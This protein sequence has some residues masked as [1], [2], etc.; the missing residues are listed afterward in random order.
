MTN[1][2]IPVTQVFRWAPDTCEDVILEID[3]GAVT[4]TKKYAGDGAFRAFLQDF[5]AGYRVFRP[6]DFPG[7]EEA[8]KAMGI[9]SI[10]V[11]YGF[12][13]HEPVIKMPGPVSIPGKI[14]LCWNP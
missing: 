3:V 14:A 9:E 12:K 8:L 10:V 11:R 1:V 2:N 13:G 7:R 4:L 5:H 6:K